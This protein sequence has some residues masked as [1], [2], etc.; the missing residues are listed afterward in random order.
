M[1]WCSPI[2]TYYAPSKAIIISADASNYGLEGAIFQEEN[3][4][5]IVIAYN[6]KRVE[7][8]MLLYETYE[9]REAKRN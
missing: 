1:D 6:E 2:L 5:L 7:T 4:T 8:K 9:S 3:K